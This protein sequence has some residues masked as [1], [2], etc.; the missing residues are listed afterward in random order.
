MISSVIIGLLCT[1]QLVI[2]YCDF[3]LCVFNEHES[4]CMHVSPCHKL[5]HK[6]IASISAITDITML[7]DEIKCV[8]IPLGVT[9]ISPL[10]FDYLFP[11]KLSNLSMVDT[12]ILTKYC[13][14]PNTAQLT[15]HNK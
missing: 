1:Y 5:L 12:Q 3:N 14:D 13:K 8:L 9:P 15:N 2:V 7:N 4:N 10:V 6:D 11:L